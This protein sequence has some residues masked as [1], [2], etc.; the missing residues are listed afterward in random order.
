MNVAC[1]EC[2]SVFRVDPAKLPAATVRARCSVCGGVITLVADGAAARDEFAAAAAP[3]P[4]VAAAP[5]RATPTPAAPIAA[6]PLPA[7]SPAPQAPAPAA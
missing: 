7:A 5:V 4:G 2:R 1:P 3:A 6:V